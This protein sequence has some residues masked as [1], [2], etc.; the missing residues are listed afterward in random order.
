VE[1]WSTVLLHWFYILLTCDDCEDSSSLSI[2]PPTSFASSKKKSLTCLYFLLLDGRLPAGRHV[3][4]N[5][6]G[7]KSVNLRNG[8]SCRPHLP[9]EHVGC[10]PM[11]CHISDQMSWTLEYSCTWLTFCPWDDSCCLKASPW[12]SIDINNN[13]RRAV[14]TLWLQGTLWLKFVD[15]PG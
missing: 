8:T 1:C 11:L 14:S 4:S 2:E 10:N 6:L 3:F 5:A 9:V 15:V 13:L 7:C 12:M